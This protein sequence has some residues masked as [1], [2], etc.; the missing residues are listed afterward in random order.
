VRKL[1]ADNILAAAVPSNVQSVGIAAEGEEFE[2]L[3]KVLGRAGV[4]RFTPL[5]AMTQFELPW[6][7]YFVPQ[8]L[9]RWTT[10]PAVAAGS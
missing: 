3:T 5:G 9:V 4:L 2:R 1:P 10:R 8:H 7:G 6:D